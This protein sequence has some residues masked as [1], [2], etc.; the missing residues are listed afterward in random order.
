MVPLVFLF[1]HFRG[2]MHFLNLF[3]ARP[4]RTAFGHFMV[5]WPL[6]GEKIWVSTGLQHQLPSMEDDSIQLTISSVLKLPSYYHWPESF[7]KNKGHTV[8]LQCFCDILQTRYFYLCQLTVGNCV[9]FFR[10][11]APRVISTSF[12][13]I[14]PR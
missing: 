1:N 13:S 4:L 2:K 9:I 3:S 7:V 14:L 5:Y 10:P 11:C 12:S 8:F 6:I